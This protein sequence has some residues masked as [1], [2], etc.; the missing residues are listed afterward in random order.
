MPLIGK[1]HLCAAACLTLAAG[2]TIAT[3]ATAAAQP[4]V[5]RAQSLLPGHAHVA[6]DIEPAHPLSA[7]VVGGAP[8][9]EGEFPFAAF[10]AWDAGNDYW[11][12][13]TGTVVA[14]T[15]ILTAAH[16][17]TDTDGLAVPTYK[18]VVVTGRTNIGM[19]GEGQI[20]NVSEVRVEPGWRYGHF[21]NDVATLILSAPVSAPA[22]RL[23]SFADMAAIGAGSKV[24]TLGWG[25]TSDGQSSLQ[26]QMMTATVDAQSESACWQASRWYRPGSMLCTDVPGHGVG[27][28]HGDS[29]GPLLTQAT[30]GE[31]VEIGLSDFISNAS[32]VD[33]PAFYQSAAAA[34]AWVLP[35]LGQTPEAPPI[36]APPVE[37]ERPFLKGRVAAGGVVH[38]MT[39]AWTGDR[40]HFRYSWSYN[41]KTLLGLTSKSIS[42]ERGARGGTLGCSVVVANDG[43]VV[44]ATSA[45]MHIRTPRR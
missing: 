19:D 40:L 42:I 43:G 45:T 4:A 34:A 8:A 17:V 30:T 44:R 21:A 16:C 37:T 36:V 32:C 9:S 25:I 23:A 38:C 27:P 18:L 5:I 11:Y 31:W 28:C 7:K 26:E 3:P 22:V 39:G 20:S 29:G 13:C 15:V 33:G 6:V 12:Q 14:P 1:P 24:Q 2:A 41:G 35:Q 10:V